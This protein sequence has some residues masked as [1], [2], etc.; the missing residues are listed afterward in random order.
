M[1]ENAK[2]YNNNEI[3]RIKYLNYA[4]T[5]A[6]LLMNLINTLLDYA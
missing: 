6:T 2:K 4:L 3:E 5:N 1:I